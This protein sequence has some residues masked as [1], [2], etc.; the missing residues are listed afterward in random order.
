MLTQSQEK[1]FGQFESEGR[2]VEFQKIETVFSSFFRRPKVLQFFFSEDQ[3]IFV[4]F[5][6]KIG[7]H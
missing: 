2:R 4:I 6:K 1:R 3:Q 7:M 5:F